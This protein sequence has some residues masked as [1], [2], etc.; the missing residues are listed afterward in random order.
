MVDPVNYAALQSQLDLSPLRQGLQMRNNNRLQQA[1]VQQRDTI[2][3]LARNKFEYDQQ[4]DASYLRDV[5]EWK[6]GGGTPEGL[7]DLALKHPDQSERMLKAGDSYN[8]VQKNDMITTGFTTMGALAAGNIELA[9]KTLSDRVTALDRARID[10][11]HTRSALDMLRKG[12]VDGART[13][14][15]YAMSGLVGADHTASVM[16][17]LGIGARAD[18]SRRDDDRADAQFKET[19]RHNRASEA[20]AAA[21]NARADRADVRAATKA[22]AGGKASGAKL[23]SGFVLD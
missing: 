8:A 1:E 7:R 5:E 21:D 9:K 14:L 4:Q 17:E 11:T 2:A 20:N 22:K 6:A 15:S 19:Q 10:S 3:Q 18:A 23:P 13:F 12:D 16:G